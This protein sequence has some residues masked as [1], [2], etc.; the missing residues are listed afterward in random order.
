MTG[1]T[2]KGEKASGTVKEIRCN[3]APKFGHTLSEQRSTKQEIARSCDGVGPKTLPTAA[4][5]QN[6]TKDYI[7]YVP[8]ATVWRAS[9][10][11]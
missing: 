10:V 7:M 2:V 9:L 3:W 1:K 4:K 8:Y 5:F 11:Y 6:I